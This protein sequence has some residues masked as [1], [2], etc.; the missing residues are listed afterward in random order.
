M[1]LPSSGSIT[2][3]QINDE[4]GRPVTQ[5][6]NLNDPEVRD[7]AEKP[8]GAISMSDFYGKTGETGKGGDKYAQP[9]GYTYHIFNS[10]GPFRWNG[11]SSTQIQYILIGGG[12]GGGGGNGGGGAGAYL[13]FSPITMSK[14]NYDMIVGSGGAGGNGTNGADGGTSIFANGSPYSDSAPGGGGGGA[15]RA[16]PGACGGGAAGRRNWHG[17]GNI[18][19]P[20][21]GSTP[22]PGSGSGRSGTDPG[23]G[24][25]GMSSKGRSELENSPG[26]RGGD[27]VT[28]SP[29]WSLPVA[30]LTPGQ[31][32]RRV[33]GG[34]G[35]GGTSGRSGGGGRDGGGNGGPDGSNGGNANSRGGGGGGAS[36]YNRPGGAG[37]KGIVAIRYVDPDTG[38]DT[39]PPPGGD[40]QAVLQSWA[41]TN[42]FSM[43]T[44]A[45]SGT[46]WGDPYSR[47]TN[48]SNAG[49]ASYMSIRSSDFSAV[50]N[51]GNQVAYKTTSIGSQSSYS[52]VTRNSCTSNSYGSFQGVR[53]EVAYYNPSTGK[54]VRKNTGSGFSDFTP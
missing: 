31:P 52:S 37:S 49:K 48:D 10:P 36:G 34:G 20:G 11:P 44:P 15:G 25:G 12:G 46:V 54:Y 47:V 21:G 41:A 19:F 45:C 8:S 50:I 26:G 32:G 13:E 3:G 7:L 27:G 5:S 17:V 33:C 35:G 38:G 42:G 4:L 23:C 51:S 53:F 24:G 16:N 6:I 9:D 22:N 28:F 39:P 30:I 1:V 2:M 43:V 29:S 18:G 14:G 40:P